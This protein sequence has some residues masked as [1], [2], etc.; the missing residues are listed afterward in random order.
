[1]ARRGRKKYRP[2]PRKVIEELKDQE[3]EL[4]SKVLAE[5]AVASDLEGAWLHVQVERFKLAEHHLEVAVAL[6]E[7]GTPGKISH[8]KR[9][10]ISRAYYAMFCAVRATLSYYKNS[11][12]NHHTNLPV[13]LAGAPFASRADLDRVVAALQ[14]FRAARNEADYSPFYPRPL[15]KDATEAIKEAKAVIRISKRW[16]KREAKA[17]RRRVTF[18]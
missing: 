6:N 5:P 2:D 9:S 17:R 18:D 1:M 12:K 11:D 7:G 8:E 4:L 10:V 15:G 3:R 13:W 16:L 14:K